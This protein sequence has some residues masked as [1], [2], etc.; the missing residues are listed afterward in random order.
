MVNELPSVP[1]AVP[2][3]LNELIWSDQASKNPIKRLRGLWPDLRRQSEAYLLQN[4]G[5]RTM[6]LP[7]RFDIYL[8]AGL[9][10]LNGRMACAHPECR[11]LAALRLCRSMGLVADSIWMTDLLS[12]KFFTDGRPTDDQLYDVLGDALVLSRLWPLIE[13][14]VIRFREPAIALC[15]GC[16]AHFDDQVEQIAHSIAGQFL[17]QLSSKQMEDGKLAFH[18]GDLYHPNLVYYVDSR[19]KASRGRVT[20]KDV[21]LRIAYESVH[22]ALWTARDAAMGGGSVFSN[23]RA[24]LAG[25]AMREGRVESR[26]DLRLLD[27]SRAFALPWVSELNPTQIVQLRSE[28]ASAL[29]V[30]REQLAHSL[31]FSDTAGAPQRDFIDG[32][33]VQAEEVKI[34]LQAVQKKSSRLWDAEFLLLSLGLGIYGS[35]ADQGIATAAS[36]LP[37]LHLISSHTHEERT[38]KSN[39]RHKPGYVLVK[40]QDILRHDHDRMNMRS[41]KV[42]SAG[43]S[44]RRT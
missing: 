32:L 17:D 41:S 31:V 5:Q 25:L 7:G 26:E 36:L 33:R 27:E 16:M 20:K 4:A 37:L 15:E 1:W 28:A 18:T 19:K 40:A 43:R 6:A 10:L 21:A 8:D 12:E 11:D 9:D 30:F 2:L 42:R 22:T 14:G 44:R 39:A 24:G 3:L 34:E 13:A 38:A 29:P 35:V 23:S